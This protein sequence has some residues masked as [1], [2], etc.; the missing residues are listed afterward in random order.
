MV[1]PVPNNLNQYRALLERAARTARQMKTSTTSEDDLRLKN[2]E[3][4]IRAAAKPLSDATAASERIT[5]ED[6]AIRITV[7]D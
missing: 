2:I 7:R 6:L 1:I 3:E 5:H 4:E